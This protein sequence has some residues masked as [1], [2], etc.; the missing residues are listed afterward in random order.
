MRM[1]LVKKKLNT[2]KQYALNEMIKSDGWRF[3]LQL[4]DEK[5][6][7]L[8]KKLIREEDLNKVKYL[9]GEIESL[10][11]LGELPGITLEID[12]YG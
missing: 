4:I 11:T 5:K 12:K 6:T 7:S 10:K 2:E 8:I 1:P 9:Q 3:Y